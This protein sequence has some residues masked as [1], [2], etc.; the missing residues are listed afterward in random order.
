[1][2]S[3]T[4]IL[5]DLVL[6][7]DSIEILEMELSNFP[8]DVEAPL[9]AIS[10]EDIVV[11]L[12]RCILDEI[13]FDTLIDWANAIECRD[14]LVFVDEVNQEL[15]IELSNPEINGGITKDK[16]QK[17]VNELEIKLLIN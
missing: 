4:E 6:L 13:S 1:M 2:R 12:K 15:I 9:Y 14:D 7:K 11:I 10:N 8:W 3:R 17:I 16:L 5:M